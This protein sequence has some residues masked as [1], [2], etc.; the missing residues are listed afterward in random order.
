MSNLTP[1]ST[2]HTTKG[3]TSIVSGFWNIFWR[4]AP[5][6]GSM[7]RNTGRALAPE[8]VQRLGD[9]LQTEQVVAVGGDVDL[10]DDVVGG[11]V[12]VHRVRAEELGAHLLLR[13][14]L[15]ELD[16]ELEAQLVELLLGV[17]LAER[18]EELI[19]VQVDGRLGR[20]GEGGWVRQTLESRGRAGRSAGASGRAKRMRSRPRRRDRDRVGGEIKCAPSPRREG[21]GAGRSRARGE[22]R[23]R[24]ERGAYHDDGVCGDAIAGSE[25]VCRRGGGVCVLAPRLRVE[26]FGGPDRLAHEIPTRD[27]DT[28]LADEPRMDSSSI[29]NATLFR[30][31]KNTRIDQNARDSDRNVP[32]GFP[33]WLVSPAISSAAAAVLSRRETSSSSSEPPSRAA[34]RRMESSGGP[35]SPVPYLRV[36]ILQYVSLDSCRRNHPHAG[37]NSGRLCGV[38]TTRASVLTASIMHSVGR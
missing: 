29:G 16:P 3:R 20:E 31:M 22:L 18:G 36:R 7:R 25:A 26:V 9:A 30:P 24:G 27:F 23:A 34:S 14:H 5:P 33:S 8:D 6:G 21:G 12:R 13:R 4:G 1:R 2:A 28:H 11:I 19:A 37:S 10:V 15:V 35:A 38:R 32:E 17:G